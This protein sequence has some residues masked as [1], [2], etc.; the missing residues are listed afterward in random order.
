MLKIRIRFGLAL[1]FI[2]A[3]LLAQDSG[4]SDAEIY[5]RIETSYALL[6][7]GT[8]QA[9]GMYVAGAR[10]KKY[11]YL[12]APNTLSVGLDVKLT[13][14][15]LDGKSKTYE[16][17]KLGADE[18]LGVA[19]YNV[20]MPIK[21][22]LPITKHPQPDQA[23]SSALRTLGA[24]QSLTS[25]QASGFSADDGSFQVT[26]SLPAPTSGL[27]IFD[28][29]GKTLGMITSRNDGSSQNATSI[30]A[31]IEFAAKTFAAAALDL[32]P[33]W[34]E[35]YPSQYAIEKIRA[36]SAVLETGKPGTGFFI[37]RDKNDVGYLL[38]ANHV[39]EDEE[40]FSIN[41]AGYEES[42]LIAKPLAGSGDANLDLA[43]VIVEEDCPPIKPVIFWAP[44]YFNRFKKNYADSTEA[45]ANVGRSQSLDDY[46]QSKQGY[47][48]GDN[49]EGQFLETD[50]QLESGDSGGP[51]FNKNGE[52]V[53]INL[54]T[55]LQ[56]SNLSV[57]NNID[58][59]LKYL[60]D[61]LKKVEFA[62]KW[63]FLEK[64]S[65]WSKN[66]SW[67]LPVGAT[68]MTASGFV[69]YNVL[70]PPVALSDPPFTPGEGTQ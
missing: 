70:K 40:E 48:R 31:L 14:Q 29:S 12:L 22:L 8:N 62:E 6:S 60:A 69:L 20:K 50:L 58:T 21:N 51:L 37:A 66:K 64:P 46:F 32:Y 19:L 49:L 9:Y 16:A 39:V 38:T 15:S 17:E 47:I 45:V 56:E 2:A 34:D 27:P 25:V 55:G 42:G 28:A 53:G 30:S 44:K 1:M 3:P 5:Q 24:N 35:V 26:G 59:I 7:D 67:I 68:T 4:N 61:K 63:E 43:I 11:V 57:A 65:Y 13:Y 10:S 52:V 33:T 36:S 18:A 41:F 54:K 23:V